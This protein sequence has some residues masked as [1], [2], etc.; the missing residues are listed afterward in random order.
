M[1]MGK[2]FDEVRTELTTQ[3]EAANTLLKE[4][5]RELESAQI[6][7][8]NKQIQQQNNTLQLL[9]TQFCSLNSQV[10][11]LSSPRWIVHHHEI[12]VDEEQEIGRGAYGTVNVATF[13]GTKVAAKRL[14]KEISSPYY[15]STFKREMDMA[16]RCRHPNLLQF[17]GATEDGDFIILTEIM[18]TSLRA[19]MGNK[20]IEDDHVVSIC[21]DVAQG[22]NYLHENYPPILH[23][24]VSSANVLLNELP[25]NKWLAKLSD[26]GTANFIR[27]TGTKNPGAI[28]YAAPEASD[29]NNQ[30]PKMDVYSYGKL[31]FEICVNELPTQDVVLPEAETL[32]S[33][34]KHSLLPLIRECLKQKQ[35]QRF[36]M[37]SIIIYLQRL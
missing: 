7:T 20:L 3:C 11:A 18:D 22:L 9:Q 13:R 4:Q 25:H 12:M 36:S 5:L 34:L 31:V 6:Q 8:L 19:A 35:E 24:D 33:P 27:N 37:R 17:I 16:G 2:R 28:V 21:L 10:K 15:V 14:H 32:W 30:T 1:E 26:Y 29:P 23:R